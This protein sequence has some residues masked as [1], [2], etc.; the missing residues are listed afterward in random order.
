MDNSTICLCPDLSKFDDVG[1]Q[2]GAVVDQFTLHVFVN[3]KT[4]GSFIR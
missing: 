2:K 3:L 4:A 1:V